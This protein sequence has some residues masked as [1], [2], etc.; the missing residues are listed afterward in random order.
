MKG[1]YLYLGKWLKIQQITDANNAIVSGA[2]DST[3]N[4]VTPVVT[5]NEIELS[6]TARLESLE[7]EVFPRIR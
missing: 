4:T 5:M 2:V 7:V 1:Q 6:G 3:G